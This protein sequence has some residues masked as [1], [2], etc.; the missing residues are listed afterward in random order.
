MY[1]MHNDNGRYFN[2]MALDYTLS[3]YLKIDEDIASYK[4]PTDDYVMEDVKKLILVKLKITT[5]K[6]GKDEHTEEPASKLTEKECFF[7][8]KKW[9]KTTNQYFQQHFYKTY[10][11][12]NFL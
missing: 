11:S 5:K 10:E 8:S 7:Y 9:F 3:D 12:K 4:S 6:S 1:K 2:T